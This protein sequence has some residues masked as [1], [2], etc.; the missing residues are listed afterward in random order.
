MTGVEGAAV[1][2]WSLSALMHYQT[3]APLTATDSEAVGLNGSN[4]ARRANIVAGQS[5][6][7]SGTCSNS[8]AVCWVNP[9]AFAARERTGCRRRPDQ[10]HHRAQFLSV[11]PIAAENI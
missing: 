10:R 3:G 5:T 2:G 9:N 11:G 6:S 7:F 1:K 8:K 4:I